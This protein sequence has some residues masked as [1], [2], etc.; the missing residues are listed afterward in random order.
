MKS[1]FVF[2]CVYHLFTTGKGQTPAS[3][4]TIQNH[5][6]VNGFVRI[7]KKKSLIFTRSYHWLWISANLISSVGAALIHLLV[8][9]SDTKSACELVEALIFK[10]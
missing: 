10:M 3:F 5:P 2:F 4:N 1:F 7:R 8:L 6:Q 9:F